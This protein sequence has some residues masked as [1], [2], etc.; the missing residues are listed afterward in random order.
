MDP[1]RTI[2]GGGRQ[3]DLAAQSVRT[4]RR[5]IPSS[6]ACAAGTLVV[7]LKRM[8][9]FV[10]MGCR[11]WIGCAVEN[12]AFVHGAPLTVSLVHGFLDEHSEVSDDRVSRLD[13]E[14]FDLEASTDLY[15][16][17]QGLVPGP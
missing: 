4:R 14:Y 15:A 6:T 5:C 16:L 17:M 7:A 13:R 1:T 2:G 12:V 10:A 3:L 11:S 8:L 9:R